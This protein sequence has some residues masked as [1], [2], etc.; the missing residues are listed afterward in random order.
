MQMWC[1]PS[2]TACRSRSRGLG[3]EGS[4]AVEERLQVGL[5][6]ENAALL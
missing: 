3:S 4:A 5:L 6:D 2:I 1:Q